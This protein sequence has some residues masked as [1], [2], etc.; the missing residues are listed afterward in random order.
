MS[1]LIRD[2]TDTEA[3]VYKSF[4]MTGLTDH[5]D[6]FRIS[7]DD[8][9]DAPFPTAGTAD[10]FT[11]LATDADTDQ[12]LGIVSFER[13]GRTRQ[14]LRH[15]GTLFRMYVAQAAA[16]Q[17]IG[18]ALIQTLLERVRLLPNMEQINLTLAAH[19]HRARKLYESVGFVS[20][21]IEPNAMKWQGR[22]V[23]EESMKLRL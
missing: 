23:D 19:N 12:W 21:G 10:S 15:K 11:L 4:F 20:Y 14:K 22:Y 17:G 6:F 9:R 3:D 16:G 18:R 2:L 1:F 8:E 13:D 5:P 7:T